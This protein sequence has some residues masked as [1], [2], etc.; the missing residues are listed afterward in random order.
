MPHRKKQSWKKSIVRATS[1]SLIDPWRDNARAKIFMAGALGCFG[2]NL[3]DLSQNYYLTGEGMFA[4]TVFNALRMALLGFFGFFIS[5]WCMARPHARVVIIVGQIAGLALVLAWPLS[6]V[7]NA[8]GF[9]LLTS[10]FWAAY[11][12]RFAI[13]Q[14]REN[15]GPETAFSSLVMVMSGS[16]G[17]FLAGWML[18][19]N[20]YTASIV[21][22][23]LPLLIATQILIMK[24]PR[25]NLI[26][27]GWRMIKRRRPSSRM[28]VY[29]GIL[30]AVQ[31]SAL[32]VWLRIMNVSPIVTG[33]MMGIRPFLGL[34]L[35]PA[36][37]H[38][39]QKGSMG[40]VRVGGALVMVGWLFMIGMNYNQLFFIPAFAFMSSGAGLILTANVS[41]WYKLRSP[42]GL[43]AREYLAAMGRSPAFFL[44][45]PLAFALP[46]AYP[47]LGVGMALLFIFGIHPMNKKKSIQI[48]DPIINAP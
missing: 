41:R 23:S 35:T 34:I 17:S 24:I 31:D 2:Y 1:A 14:S 25:S 39:V 4:I 15:Y 44:V 21:I 27:R 28:S 45:L 9:A 13:K 11:H 32:P 3:L 29:C 8:V 48:I 16:A 7:G 46:A 26:K 6:A 40:A 33:F 30:H 42:A 20:N 38:L 10:S 5:Y 37:G 47:F 43:M 12:I 22:S 19:S 36:I 18:H